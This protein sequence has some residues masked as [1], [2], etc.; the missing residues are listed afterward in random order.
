MDR[1]KQA[2]IRP[3]YMIYIR[4]DDG[5]EC[6]YD[7]KYA[8]ENWPGYS[9]LRDISGLFSQMKLDESRTVLYWND[10]IDIPSD[11]IRK[12]AQAL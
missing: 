11:M 9:D 5:K 6:I 8:I 2:E 10:Y 12:K 3:D 4:F 1:I 7:M